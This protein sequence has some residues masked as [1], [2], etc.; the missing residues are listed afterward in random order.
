MG[1][2]QFARWKCE[3][4]P[5]VA[6]LL[7]RQHA[8]SSQFQWVPANLQMVMVSQ[9]DMLQKQQLYVAAKVLPPPGMQRFP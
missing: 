9:P 1:C 4:F 7:F 6:T 8:K 5:S 3:P 2:S